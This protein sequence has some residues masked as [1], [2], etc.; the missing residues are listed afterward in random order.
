MAKRYTKKESQL[1]EKAIAFLVVEYT[2]SGFNEKPVIFHSLRVACR[3]VEAGSPAATVAAAVLHD[4]LEDSHVTAKQMQKSFGKK[5]TDLVS[6]VSFKPQIQNKTKQYQEMFKR[7]QAG[8]PEAL[9]I[10]CA[11]ILDNSD[12]YILGNNQAAEQ[13]LM[14]KLKYFLQI[15]ELQL[16]KTSLFQDLKKRYQMLLAQME[17]LN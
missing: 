11:D 12:Y 5:I 1:I 16:R 7:T 15:A 10:K 14:D 4:L 9:I 8:G 3:L 17:Q 2:K 6:V 13:L